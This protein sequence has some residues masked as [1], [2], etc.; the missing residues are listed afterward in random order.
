MSHTMAL[1][2]FFGKVLIHKLLHISVSGPA[3]DS[4]NIA[5]S[6]YKNAHIFLPIYL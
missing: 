6:V 1:K 2:L 5:E 4:F 3:V